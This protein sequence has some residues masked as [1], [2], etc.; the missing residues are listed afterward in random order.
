MNLGMLF[1]TIPAI[2]KFRYQKSVCS[3]DTVKSW[4]SSIVWLHGC[5][6]AN[7]ATWHYYGS[8][9]KVLYTW[10]KLLAK[11]KIQSAESVTEQNIE[12]FNVRLNFFKY[13]KLGHCQ[14]IVLSTRSL[15]SNIIKTL[16]HVYLCKLIKLS[17]VQ[18]AHWPCLPS[19]LCFWS[20]S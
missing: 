15:W 10:P 9:R 11:L 4:L 3:F 12:L 20:G 17:M 18:A 14:V 16:S 2:V 13:R 1:I 5:M 8:E 19:F 6:H 7:S